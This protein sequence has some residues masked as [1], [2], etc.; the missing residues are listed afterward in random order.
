MAVT[1]KN[2]LALFSRPNVIQIKSIDV[3]NYLSVG[4]RLKVV[5]HVAVHFRRNLALA[6]WIVDGSVETR[7]N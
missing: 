7:S 6:Q 5:S 1:L 3:F 2:D 4:E